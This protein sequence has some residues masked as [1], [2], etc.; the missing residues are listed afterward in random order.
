MAK[1]I[2]PNVDTALDPVAAQIRASNDLGLTPISSEKKFSVDVQADRL[3]SFSNVDPSL[4]KNKSLY[5]NDAQ[6]NEILTEQRAREQSGVEQLLKGLG[7]VGSTFATEVLKTPGYLLGGFGALANDKSV[8]ENIVDNDWVNAFDKLDDGLKEMMP[9]HLTKEV[10]EGNIG[11]KLMSSAWWATTGADG[12]GFLLSMYAPGQL[13]KA[14]NIGAKIGDGLQAIAKNAKLSK[15][16]TATSILNKDALIGARMTEK[17]IE[18]ANSTASFMMNTYIESAAEAANTFDNARKTFLEQNPDATDED[19]SKHASSAAANVMKANVPLLLVSNVLDEL[20]LFKGFGRSAEEVASKSTLG[21]LFKNGMFDAEALSQIKRAGIKDFMK[22]VPAKLAGNFAKEGLF[23]E[24]FQTQ[25]QNHYENVAAGKTKASFTEDVIGNYYEN[26][27]T[28]P[29]LQES[30]VLGGILGGGASMFGLAG[31]IKAKNN[32]LFGAESSTPSFLGRMMGQ[33]AKTGG[34]GLYNMMQEN[35]INSTRTINDIAETDADGKPI[36][37]NGKPKINEEKLKQMVEQKDGLLIL[38]QLHNLAILKGDKAEENYFGD[39]LSYNYFLPFLQQ[40][41]GFEVLNGHIS[42]QLVELM[43]KKQEA[44][45]G[46]A[47]NQ[48]AKDKLKAKL[49]GKAAE[50]KKIYDTVDTTTTTEMYVPVDNPAAYNGWKQ[51]VR[52][53]KMQ[54]LVAYNSAQRGI[55][56]ARG[57]FPDLDLD[58]E[59]DTSSMSPD[60]LIDHKIGTQI[61]KQYKERADE[62]KLKYVELSEAK[63]L[64]EDYAKFGKAIQDEAEALTKEAEKEKAETEEAVNNQLKSNDFE[65]QL[66][67]AGY[68]TSRQDGTKGFGLKDPIIFLENAKGERVTLEV[69]YN[70]AT[71]TLEQFTRDKE[72]KLTKITD[73]NGNY[74]PSFSKAGFKPIP[75]DQIKKEALDIKLKRRKDSQL[76]LLNEIITV[77]NNTLGNHEKEVERIKKEL[78]QYGEEMKNIQTTIDNIHSE[79]VNGRKRGKKQLKVR[80]EELQAALNTVKKTID[81]LQERKN[82]LEETIPRIQMV[83]A[84]FE[85]LKEDFL[86]SGDSF[87]FKQEVAKIEQFLTGD[88]T[89]VGTNEIIQQT[90]EV[91][92]DIEE[93][94]VKL[95]KLKENIEK[96]LASHAVFNNVIKLKELEYENA[97]TDFDMFFAGIPIPYAMRRIH[98]IITSDPSAVVNG[99]TLT[100]NNIITNAVEITAWINQNPD[101]RL[102]KFNTEDPITE[103]DVYNKMTEIFTPYVA[104]MKELSKQY[105]YTPEEVYDLRSQVFITNREL[106]NLKEELDKQKDQVEIEKMY[107]RYIVLQRL[108][109]EKIEARFNTILREKAEVDTD[110]SQKRESVQTEVIEEP[111]LTDIFLQHGLPLTPFSTTGISVLYNKDGADKGKDQIDGDGL[112]ILNDNEFQRLWF[113]TIDELSESIT[114]YTLTPVRATYKDGVE[115]GVVDD[116]QEALKANFPDESKRGV[117]DVFVFLTHK[118]GRKVKR[119]GVYV[120]TSVR[121]V[122]EV[123]PKGK[124]PRVAPDYILNEY[125]NH[126]GIPGV[127]NYDK[128]KNEKISNFVH[129]VAARQKLK[130]LIDND[131]NGADLFAMAIEYSKT[132]YQAFLNQLLANKDPNKRIQIEDVTTGKPLYQ[133]DNK[134]QKIRHNVLKMF[135]KVI[136][137]PKVFG[138]KQLVGGK[139]GVVV[140]SS[141]KVKNRFISLPQGTVYFQ[142]DNSDFMALQSRKIN[143]QEV[144]TI[145]YLLS[146]ANTT[147]GLNTIS[148]EA[149]LDYVLNGKAVGKNLPVFFRKSQTNEQSFSLLETLINYGLRSADKNKKGEIYIQSGKVLFTDFDGNSHSIELTALALA[150]QSRD[151]TK[152]APLVSFLKEKNFNVNNTMLA[153]NPIFQYPVYKDG[154]LK[155]ETKSSYYEFLLNGVLTTSAMNK[156]GYPSRM[157][158]NVVYAPKLGAVSAA[159]VTAKAAVPAT[160]AAAPAVVP[161]P[162]VDTVDSIVKRFVDFIRSKNE[163]YA[164]LTKEEVL[165]NIKSSK[166]LV[167]KFAA[168]GLTITDKD[169][170]MIADKILA[171]DEDIQSADS[172]LPKADAAPAPVAEPEAKKMTAKERLAASRANASPVSL[173]STPSADKRVNVEELLEKYIESKIVQKNCK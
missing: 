111:D 23:E 116:V 9:V 148:V 38:N 25:I 62:A 85:S 129:G 28:N 76:Q 162:T 78:E 36:F 142:F 154:K 168:I 34:K 46:T 140:N 84:E 50:Y 97:F 79:K 27:M 73:S 166:P 146:L 3:N 67:T 126:L 21:K 8:I 156:E 42:N 88:K 134:G 22:K 165:A 155:F 7:H 138:Q 10:Q 163:D 114:D 86:N 105:P 118:D 158:R 104:N 1:I 122:D 33:K 150:V 161:T 31:E 17:G 103:I 90:L 145:M 51:S 109:N 58:T 59:P 30:V 164:S 101:F 13:L 149:P 130:D 157:Q 75:A 65:A 18:R 133:L 128:I 40:E 80:Q 121:T 47:P 119:N 169:Y 72:G 32:M 4:S 172:L 12:I 152:V 56:E 167:A 41:G 66:N 29:E 132:Q 57:L 108:L 45:T 74:L 136:L 95:N 60:Q 44:V 43:A 11:R 54:S 117:N 115:D 107:R 63:S 24:G 87:S 112:P 143:E 52:D 113:Q 68:G 48:D 37:E 99:E 92:Q 96:V 151:Y 35:F 102:T 171:D 19:A 110:G 89:I 124:A 93:Q 127:F 82:Y 53:R 91:I 83:I 64:R 77:R 5:R 144:D 16:L 160:V 139:L 26:L 20:F 147:A 141:I 159:P 14:V 49:L 15:V 69:K 70:K 123:F 173:P 2:T 125:L 135:P 170:D 137:N 153:N 6:A 55:T 94:I 98:Q 120:F 81:N 100:K 71:N 61:I 131:N 39:L 106:D